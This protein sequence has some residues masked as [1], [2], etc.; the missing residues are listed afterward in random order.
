[1]DRREFLRWTALMALCGTTRQVCYGNG[2]RL[3]VMAVNGPLPGDFLGVTLP[4]E[5]VMTDFIGADKVT[6][7]RYDPDEVFHA[8]L[9]HLRR[10]KDAGLQT[11]V[12]CTPAFIGRDPALLARLS[13]ASGLAI[14]TN[15][16]Y[17]GA[18]GRI[19][20]PAHAYAETVERLSARWI[21]EWREGIEGTG[22]RPGF[23]KTGT[24]AGKL[25]EINRKLIRA[26]ARTHLATG[27]TIAAHSGDGIAAFEQL[28]ILDE[29]GVDPSAFIWVHAHLETDTKLHV[30]AAE[31]G[32]WLEFDGL[33]DDPNSIRR[34]LNLVRSMRE[35]G[36]L[37]RVLLSHD[38][39][40]YHVGEP[41]GGVFRPFDTLFT[42]FIPA[43]KEAAS[44][45]D[46]RQITVTNPMEAFA[47]R[48]R[49]SG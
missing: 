9:P 4:H 37:E 45:D 13:S 21:R 41:G 46:V 11:L 19:F 39:G 12:E 27:L 17:Y 1:M 23:I 10:A 43:L 36:L 40:W 20:I 2:S 35:R 22:I 26:A 44:S 15:T 24:D 3:Q 5:H 18:A 48:V 7:D 29:E 28:K 34:H 8:V 32:A 47:I 14:L 16:G 42:R 33:T 6:K 31:A 30:R 38:A 49:R 25:R